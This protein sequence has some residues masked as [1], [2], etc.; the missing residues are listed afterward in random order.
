MRFAVAAIV[1][2]GLA[3]LAY[4]A[5]RSPN[6]TYR[7]IVTLTTDD[8]RVAIVAVAQ[9]GKPIAAEGLGTN[10][11]RFAIVADEDG[12]PC[13]SDE[14]EVRTSN[15]VIHYPR[16]NLCEAKWRIALATAVQPP[17]P[18]LRPEPA[19]RW[20]RARMT[21]T[22]FPTEALHYAVPETDGTVMT[23]T[24]Q[25]GAGRITAK[26][27]GAFNGL[28]GARAARIDF[29]AP[30]G[31]LRYDAGVSD[32]QT[33]GAEETMPFEIEQSAANIFWSDLA[34]GVAMPFRI[35]H[36]DFL[37]LDATHGAAQIAAFVRIC[38][39]R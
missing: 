27:S 20:I 29:Y 17:P 19:L 37:V 3:A 23:A 39:A 30:T 21:D 28:K 15:G 24:C 36:A 6:E 16:V 18:G 7:E 31:V 25:P 33:E 22:P 9:Y 13:D 5:L 8:P 10:Q 26:F 32:V 12:I 35:Q 4:V 14:L 38:A 1:A 34:R 2:V 11:V